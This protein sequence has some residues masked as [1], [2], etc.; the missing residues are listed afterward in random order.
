MIVVAVVVVVIGY[1]SSCFVVRLQIII[2]S[3]KPVLTIIITAFIDIMDIIPT[4]TS[5][6]TFTGNTAAK[7]ITTLTCSTASTTTSITPSPP[8]SASCDL[9]S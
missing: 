9:Y 3:F 5:G 4:D 2:A 7:T 1:T 6:F 8:A